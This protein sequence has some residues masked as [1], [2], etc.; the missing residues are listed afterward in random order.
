MKIP[1]YPYIIVYFNGQADHNIHG[2]VN[3]ETA[4]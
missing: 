3:E 1:E 4:L 2:P